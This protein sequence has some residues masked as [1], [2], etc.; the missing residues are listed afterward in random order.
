[1]THVAC[2]AHAPSERPQM[3]IPDILL[4]ASVGR[5]RPPGLVDRLR[6][7]KVQAMDRAHDATDDLWPLHFVAQGPSRHDGAL[8]G[9]LEQV[10]RACPVPLRVLFASE[11]GPLTPV[12]EPAT[13]A[14]QAALL[15]LSAGVERCPFWAPGREGGTI[16]PSQ[17]DRVRLQPLASTPTQ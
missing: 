9:L 11:V 10:C 15:F 2:T 14:R 6:L 13:A 17:C 5:C 1:M 16:P 12:I 8:E 7:H 3:G 4:G